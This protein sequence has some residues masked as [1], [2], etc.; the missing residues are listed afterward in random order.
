MGSTGHKGTDHDSIAFD[1]TALSSLL[2]EVADTLEKLG[3]FIAGDSAYPLLPYLMVPY[4]DCQ[5]GT[6][7]DAFNF[8]LSNSRIRIEC[9]FG[10]L[11]MRWGIFWRTLKFDI[12]SAGNIINAAM[13]LHNFLIDVRQEE[14]DGYFDRA[15]FAS[16]SVNTL[17]EDSASQEE[18]NETPI[19]LVTDN[20]EPKPCGRKTKQQLDMRKRGE[21][22]RA[23]LDTLLHVADKVRPTTYK[24]KINQLGHVY[25]EA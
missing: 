15:F 9:A 11:V 3:V 17:I 23:R 5:P 2:Q 25:F 19:S 20:N 18:S 24:M 6:S 4:D 21:I 10:E 1:A 16:F 22:V 14:E 12:Q 8:W 13:L 7:E